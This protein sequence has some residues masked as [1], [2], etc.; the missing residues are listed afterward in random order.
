MIK[1]PLRNKPVEMKFS[2]KEI[3]FKSR[4]MLVLIRA[5]TSIYL[6]IMLNVYHFIYW[7][8]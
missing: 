5:H 8:V 4:H 7:V 3:K 6:W 2:A 1:I